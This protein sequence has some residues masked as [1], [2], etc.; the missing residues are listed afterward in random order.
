MLVVPARQYLLPRVFLPVHLR[1]LDMAEYEEAPA[2]S[3]EETLQ[4]VSFT[5][6]IAREI[7][8]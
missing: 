5:K 8:L 7:G 3:P 4:V 6:L 1:E 2:L